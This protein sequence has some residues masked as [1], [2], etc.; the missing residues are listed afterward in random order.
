MH[1]TSHRRAVGGSVRAAIVA[2][3]LAVGFALA[4]VNAQE[5]SG[6][7]CQGDMTK[8]Q[9]KR[10]GFLNRL[11]A[12]TKAGKGKLDPIAAC[13]QL[14]NLSAV[15]G[16]ILAYMTKNQNW[17]DIPD[18]VIENVKEGSQ[19]TAEVAGQACK[20]AA[21]ARRMQQQQAAGGGGAPAAPR[22]PT[23]PL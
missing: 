19:K 17:C 6:S 9:Q 10:E 14:R 20:I 12:L 11:N 21:Q 8:L 18:N 1:G 15:E 22:L 3:A 16:Q 2:T 5:L 23:G 4:P 13:P 7:D